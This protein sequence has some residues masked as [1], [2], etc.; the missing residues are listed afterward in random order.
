MENE[1]YLLSE[2]IGR[3]LQNRGLRIATG[4]SCTGGWIAQTI[5]DVPGSSVWFD[6]GFVTY[7]NQAKVQLLDVEAETLADF[8]A[9]SEEVAKQ[10]LAGVL[11][12]SEA[13]IAIAVTGIAGPGGGSEEKPVGTVY[14]GWQFKNSQPVVEKINLCGDRYQIRKKTVVFSLSKLLTLLPEEE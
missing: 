11:R 8:G 2:K 4:E 5:T 13:D 3:R 14:I 6:R 9:V 7:S 12:H 10:M 1:L